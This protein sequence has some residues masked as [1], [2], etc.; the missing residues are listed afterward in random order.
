M[1]WCEHPL[2]PAWSE[3]LYVRTPLARE[4]GDPLVGHT[5]FGARGVRREGEEP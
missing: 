3:T 2:D 1:R 4:P 5:L